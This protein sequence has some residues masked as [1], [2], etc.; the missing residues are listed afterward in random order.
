[1]QINA[2]V[3]LLHARFFAGICGLTSKPACASVHLRV[4]VRCSI[5]HELIVAFS[6][7]AQAE[8]LNSD[9]YRSLASLQQQSDSG[10]TN[11][12]VFTHCLL[13]KRSRDAPMAVLRFWAHV[14]VKPLRHNHPIPWG[15]KSQRLRVTG[16]PKMFF[17]VTWK[18]VLYDRQ[19]PNLFHYI[20]VPDISPQFCEKKCME[21][22]VCVDVWGCVWVAV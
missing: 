15:L 11:Q 16:E 6:S 18:F 22:A 2:K 3:T 21:D 19:H 14:L 10:Q 7:I 13:M 12:Y 4:C 8:L 17:V 1:M 5:W 20:T 9:D